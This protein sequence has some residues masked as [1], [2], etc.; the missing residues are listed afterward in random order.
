MSFHSIFSC[1]L[2]MNLKNNVDLSKTRIVNVNQK[3][4]VLSTE[5]N[6]NEKRGQAHFSKATEKMKLKNLIIGA[7]QNEKNNPMEARRLRQ[8]IAQKAESLYGI[9]CK[10]VMGSIHTISAENYSHNLSDKVNGRK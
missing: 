10:K 6:L 1:A 7:R 9:D 3:K 4:V 2:P 5:R 8:K